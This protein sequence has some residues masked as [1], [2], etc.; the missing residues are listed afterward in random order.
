MKRKAHPSDLTDEQWKILAPL[1]PA[2]K[3][4]GR[5]RTVDIREVMDGI[6]YVLR[7]GVIGV[8]YFCLCASITFAG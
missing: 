3:P 1:L 6:Q 2:A 5:P 4:G 7:T 8:N